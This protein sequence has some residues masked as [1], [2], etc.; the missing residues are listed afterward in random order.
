[1]LALMYIVWSNL[2]WIGTAQSIWLRNFQLGFFGF[3]FG[4]LAAN[5][6]DG[7]GINEKGFLYGF[8]VVVVGAIGL[9][10]FGGLV[11]AV[12]IKYTDNIIKGFA[13]C[14]SIILTCILSIY[15][16]NFHVNGYFIYGSTLVIMSSYLYGRYQA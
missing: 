1:M 4:L 6:S 14:F 8:D 9:Q 2:F 10:S 13:T 15:F 7:I 5:F 3:T 11:I 16:F 12:V